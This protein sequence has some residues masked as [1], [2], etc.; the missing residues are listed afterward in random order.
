MRA[1]AASG[2]SFNAGWRQA[3]RW[4]SAHRAL[5]KALCYDCWPGLTA[6]ACAAEK[7]DSFM[8]KAF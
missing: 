2:W 5:A 7:L 1:G 6:I 3:G 4:F 8:K